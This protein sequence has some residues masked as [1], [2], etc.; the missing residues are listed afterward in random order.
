MKKAL[1]FLPVIST[2]GISKMT[3]EYIKNFSDDIQCEV[4]TL[5][6][7]NSMYFDKMNIKIHK[8][9]SSQNIIGKLKNEI[10]FMKNKNYDILHVNG[11]SWHRLTEC[12]AGKIAKIQKR[13]IHSHNNGTTNN[14]LKKRIINKIMKKFFDY[15][16]TN[17]I[18]CSEESAKWLFS[19]KIYTNNKY[20]IL[21]NGICIE[22]FK[23]NNETRKLYR[24]KLEIENNQMV[25]G[26]I[27]RLSYQ[28]NPLFLLQILYEYKKINEN[29][30]LI[31]IGTGELYK[32]LN[33]EAQKLNITNNI[34]FIG[35]VANVNDFYNVM[36]C[37]ILPSRYEGFGIVA[38]EAQTSGLK[39]ILS[40]NVP[41]TTKI[42]N[43]TCYLPLDGPIENWINEI[44]SNKNR[45]NSY[46]NALKNNFEIKTVTKKL[47]K[48][49]LN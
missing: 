41:K 9:K 26:F 14:S 20:I 47:E 13:I 45:E 16:A 30:L 46:I 15:F 6:I 39:T 7:E 11:N 5:K 35:N 12:L 40:N 48:L 34:I 22:N 31:I 37:F 44:K 33:V 4:L 21:N 36:D 24:K 1:I 3:S 25:I 17:Y 2:D 10:N 29:V 38:I 49:Y 23:F 42:N 19:K 8:L 32:K 27:G 43:E 28:K 18:A